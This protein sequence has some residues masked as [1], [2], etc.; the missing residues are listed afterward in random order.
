MRGS[1]PSLPMLFLLS[2]ALACSGGEDTPDT[3]ADAGPADSGA[4]GA[5]AAPADAG[6]ADSGV[7]PDAGEADAGEADAGEADGGIAEP[8]PRVSCRDFDPPCLAFE[9]HQRD[10]LLDAVNELEGGTTVVLGAGTF[11]L[12]NALSIRRAPG[13]TFTGQGIDVTV[14][15]FAAQPVQTNGVDVVSDDFTISHLTVTDAKKDGIRIEASTNVIIRSVK[16]TWAGGPATTNGSYGIYPVRCTNVLLEDSEAYNASDAGLYVGQSI[17]VIVRNNLAMGNVAGLEIENT[18]YADV[19]GNRVEDNTAGLMVFDLPGNPV[20][21]RDVRIHGNTVVNNNRANFAPSGT[22][23]SQI[24][25]GTG[26]F[27]LA[28]RRVEITGNEY[29]NNATTD[30]AILSGLVVQGSTMAWS[31]PTDRVVGDIEGLNLPVS[32]GRLYNFRT[33]EIWVHGNSHAESGRMPDGNNQAAR[34]LG[35]LLALVYF[36]G[37]TGPVDNI[38][39]DGVGETV[40][41]T[42]PAANT[43]RNHICVGA[44]KGGTFAVL[45]IPRLAAIAQGGGLPGTDDIYQPSPPFA[46]FDCRDFTAG[47]IEPVTLPFL[48]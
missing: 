33:D 2:F 15:D 43:N 23:V 9:A 31:I 25:R 45:D 38:L 34:P 32:D 37:G 47:P 12:E 40:S 1:L 35:A 48:P 13:V 44:A 3:G 46:P 19:Y 21:G 22:V 8:F 29:R 16:V 17:N 24:P 5:D 39:Y 14:L 11:E 42:E 6:P 18:Q 4:S 27:A 30:I 41:P 10:E 28:S 36:V 26:T 7:A 20:V